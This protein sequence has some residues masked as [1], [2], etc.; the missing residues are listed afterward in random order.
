MKKYDKLRSQLYASTKGD[1]LR[2]GELRKL[3]KAFEFDVRDGA[4]GGHKVF[5]HPKISNWAGADFNCGHKEGDP[6]KSF[7]KK[8]ILQIVDNFE[9]ELR[10]ILDG[11]E[12]V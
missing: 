9:S 2:C 5:N 3:L 11:D 8:K 10:L 7:Y 6:V 1:N 12:N 4:N